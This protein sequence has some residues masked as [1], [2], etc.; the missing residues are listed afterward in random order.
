MKITEQ[1]V[2]WKYISDVFVDRKY[3]YTDRHRNT[4]YLL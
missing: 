2:Y 1:C 4:M 3:Q